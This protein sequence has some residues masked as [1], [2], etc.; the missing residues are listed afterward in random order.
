MKVTDCHQ[1]TLLTEKEFLEKE[2]P[3]LSGVFL[4]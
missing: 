4:L 1:T 3:R 2:K